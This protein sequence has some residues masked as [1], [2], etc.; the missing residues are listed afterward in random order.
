MLLTVKNVSEMLEWYEFDLEV[1]PQGLHLVDL[2]GANLGGIEG[3]VFSDLKEVVDRL[4]VYHED[5]VIRDIENQYYDTDPKENVST[6]EELLLKS[7]ELNLEGA[8][9]LEMI[10][11]GEC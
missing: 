11:E 4:S 9:F 7:K 5:Y 6:W 10:V 3:E 2:Q 1:S 8:Y